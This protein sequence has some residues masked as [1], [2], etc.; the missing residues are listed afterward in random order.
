LFTDAEPLD[1]RAQVEGASG[2]VDINFTIEQIA[3]SFR[4]TGQILGIAP[5]LMQAPLDLGIK[6]RGLYRLTASATDGVET[7]SS[8]TWVSVVFTPGL[9][10]PAS[11]WAIFYSPPSWF[12]KSPSGAADA[13][14]QHRLLGAA[15]SRL[16]FWSGVFQ[17][18][19]IDG[20]QI[21]AE[22]PTWKQ[23]ADA[24]R[25]EGIS[26]LGEVAGMPK[27]LSSQPNNTS[28][29][30]TFEGGPLW[31]AVKP[32]NY[33]L[34]DQLMEQLAADFRDSIQVWE[35]WNEADL[36][37][38]YW[39]GT[40]QEYIELVQHT[41]QALKRGNPD[42]RIAAGGFTSGGLD[43][44]DCLLA[45]GLGKYI[46]ILS[47][48]YTDTN[49]SGC[50]VEDFR[51]ALAKHQLDIPIWN[52]EESHEI[53]L[54]NIASG[55]QHSFKFLH[56]AP[57][58]MYDDLHPLV[59]RDWTATPTAIAFAVGA[60]AIGSAQF[61][62]RD[63]S[64]QDWDATYYQR[65]TE[66][67]AVLKG[68]EP[69]YFEQP[70]LLL[71][72]TALNPT[73]PPTVIDSWGR[74]APLGVLNG[75]A[76]LPLTDRLLIINGASAVSIS[77]PAVRALPGIVV[78]EAENGRAGGGGGGW[79]PRGYPGYSSGRTMDVLSDFDP[80][81]SYWMELDLQVPADGTYELLFSGS[82]LQKLAP[83]RSVSPFIWNVDGGQ[84]RVVDA[85]LPQA[86]GVQAMAEP[87]SVLDTITL[88]QGQ[89]LFRLE[90]S[91]RRDV[92]DTRYAFR[93]DAVVLRKQ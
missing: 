26:I 8:Q 23:Y 81:G 33:A 48:H 46:D 17:N 71:S 13:A 5:G 91:G 20:D 62:G 80:S 74:S 3:G 34:W 25:A 57:S 19:T 64:V 73:S 65:G 83:P 1:V 9:P 40:K 35:I 43:Y 63:R 44:V 22:Y 78:A 58:A 55:I 4:N 67:I 49:G 61:V 92:P 77:D 45:M 70:T 7:T 21:R 82:D 37:N 68:P 69:R 90:L 60:H 53:P 31:E 12:D 72:L 41:S 86:S 89:H 50:V 39:A 16:N 52:T 32:A 75:Q 29:T 51:A 2:P 30:S 54:T 6:E 84:T 42:A 11:H 66:S 10:D 15:W 56:V 87:P 88:T 27:L 93:F 76:T 18:L 47:V 28:P 36:P 14:L 38:G 59:H 85:P 24:L 79:I